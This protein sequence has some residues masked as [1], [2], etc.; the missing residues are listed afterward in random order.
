MRTCTRAHVCTGTKILG[1]LARHACARL[2]RTCRIGMIMPDSTSCVRL[3]WKGSSDQPSDKPAG[4]VQGHQSSVPACLHACTSSFLP[5]PAHQRAC[6]LSTR[7]CRP[8]LSWYGMVA[9]AS[10]CARP[11]W[12]GR[13]LAWQSGPACLRARFTASGMRS[14]SVAG[15]GPTC[16][17]GSAATQDGL[18]G[19]LAAKRR[20]R[21]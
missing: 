18:G 13:G 16:R 7:C 5:S 3:R 8:V 15:S 14:V 2:Y 1:M 21:R 9:H 6:R 4:I 20:A 17:L 11:A 10:R 19:C 12:P